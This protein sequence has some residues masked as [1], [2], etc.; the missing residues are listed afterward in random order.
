MHS[1]IAFVRSLKPLARRDASLEMPRL[2]GPWAWARRP[3]IRRRVPVCPP[4]SP[5][6]SLYTAQTPRHISKRS[7]RRD[8]TRDHRTA[9]VTSR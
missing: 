6:N 7:Y 2:P 5:G 9:R 3:M 8:A 1:S 4:T